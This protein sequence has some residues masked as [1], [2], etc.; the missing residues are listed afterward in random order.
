MKLN[1]LEPKT[2]NNFKINDIE[3]DIN[4]PE[5]NKFKAYNIVCDEYNDDDNVTIKV[6]DKKLTNR[7]GLEF[8]KYYEINVVIPKDTKIGEPIEFIYKFE[9]KDVLVEK[10]NIIFEEN[11]KADI[12]IKHVSLDDGK[13]FHNLNIDIKNNKYSNGSVSIVNMLNDNSYNFVSVE[14]DAYSH[15]NIIQNIIDIG[16][17]TRLYNVY[18]NTYEYAYNELNTIYIGTNKDIIDINYYLNNIGIKSNNKMTVQG[19][20]DGYSNKNF[21]GTLDFKE[22]S[23]KSI[24]DELENCVL[25]SDT[26]ISRSLPMMLCHE[27]DV[28]GAHG[29]SSGKV[30]KNKLF[31]LNTRGMSK[32]EAE[33]FIIK[34]N[35]NTILNKIPN[36]Q[37]QEEL[38]SIIDKKLS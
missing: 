13:H 8:N 7:I 14:N 16:A 30:D 4:I 25:L 23:S 5:V 1:K 19:A 6:I 17:S 34:S 36:K 22:G 24:G 21:R 3:L 27:E 37:L 35:F 2:T 29:V 9:D 20:L 10:F 38:E 33:K 28:V 18:T 11:S 32:K 12:I 31:Y 26:C 15:S